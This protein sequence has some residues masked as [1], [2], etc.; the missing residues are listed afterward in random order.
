MEG[1][2][3]RSGAVF[4]LGIW[5][6]TTL[7]ATAASACSTDDRFACA[8]TVVSSSSPSNETVIKVK[9]Q[10]VSKPSLRKRS[11][12]KTATRNAAR[13]RIT[14]SSRVASSRPAARTR[15]AENSDAK[16]SAAASSVAVTELP[17]KPAVIKRIDPA[18]T[19]APALAE[20]GEA[21]GVQPS[22]EIASAGS[23]FAIS[24]T[25]QAISELLSPL[26][27]AGAPEIIRVAVIEPEAP[28]PLP[29]VALAEPSALEFKSDPARLFATSAAAIERP[30]P[31]KNA[32]S[33]LSWVQAILLTLGGSIVG[34]SMF[35]LYGGLK[36]SC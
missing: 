5:L 28:K 16:V 11:A 7:A 27:I 2:S 35:K 36:S 34:I 15:S 23:T 12:E 26:P 8:T 22:Y 29:T 32:P 4:G 31:R 24:G 14:K 13:A 21:H 6:V 19:T 30:A 18:H 1:R 17:T 33:G 10:R 3:M 25:P 20:Q 9:S